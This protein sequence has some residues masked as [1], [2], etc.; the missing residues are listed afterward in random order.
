MGSSTRLDTKPGAS[1]TATGFLP[2]FSHSD[3]VVAKVASLV[4]SPRITS[5]STITGTGFMKCMPMKFSGRLVCAASCVME[6]EEVL[7]A[8]ITPGRRTR[9]GFFQHAH[10][11]IELLGNRLDDEIGGGE[12]LQY[13]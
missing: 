7:L 2:S 4:A 12:R 1:F 5:T 6:I 10:F 11:Q 8:R 9:V 3:I 13:R